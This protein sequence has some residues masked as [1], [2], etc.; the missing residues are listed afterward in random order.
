MVYCQEAVPTKRGK[1]N[2][3]VVK[4]FL[5]TGLK[6]GKDGKIDMK[7]IS[8]LDA[9]F[10]PVNYQDCHWFVLKMDIKNKRWS[11]LDSIRGFIDAKMR[12]YIAAVRWSQFQNRAIVYDI[13]R[14]RRTFLKRSPAW[15]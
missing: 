9:I 8:S 12:R 10:I 4:L 14:L 1:C 7:F 6:R 11:F 5:L 2:Q 13:N 15:T 3:S